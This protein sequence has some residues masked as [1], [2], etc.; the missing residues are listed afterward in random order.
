MC[1]KTCCFLLLL[2]ELARVPALSDQSLGGKNGLFCLI[3]HIKTYQCASRKPNVVWQC[4]CTFF[5]RASA[6]NVISSPAF[7]S[8]YQRGS[9]VQTKLVT[10]EW[11]S[12]PDDDEA[13]HS[14]HAL[15]TMDFIQRYP[16]QY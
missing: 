8:S 3:G 15:M 11:L 13:V 6:R 14:G 1:C 12:S 2:K 9:P 4:M 16:N 5:K 10:K 7:W